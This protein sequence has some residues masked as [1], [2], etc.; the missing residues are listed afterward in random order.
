[1][2]GPVDA[3]DGLVG[4]GRVATIEVR[5][6]R[7]ARIGAMD[8]LRVLP[9]K[10][11]RTVGAWCFVDL[12]SP[13]D[14]D[15]PPP[16]EVGPH[17]HIGLSTVTWLFSGSALHSDSLGTEQL[18]RPGQLNL[19]SAG[20]GIAHAELGVD[21]GPAH[22]TEGVMGA[23]MW[24]AQ[25]DATRHGPSGFVHIADVPRVESGEAVVTVLVGEHGGETSPAATDHP[26]VGLDVHLNR[27]TRIE[28]RP[29]FEYGVVPIDRPIS[30]DGVIGE[31]GSL[32]LVPIGHESLALDARSDRARMMIV[33]GAPLDS[34]IQMWWN[35]VARS[36][37]EITAAWRDWRDHNDDRF[38]PVPS[39][40][41]RI[42]APVPPWVEV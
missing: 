10:G 2:S 33:G 30:V 40:L 35:F 37:D 1:M 34:R 3:S 38:G 27:S 12:M 5:E 7:T 28:I 39:E 31:P 13:E 6:G 22:D 42:E 9:T 24:L 20:Q 36:R 4:G 41:A 18:I 8:V 32:V 26:T 17:P 11:R 14:I 15:N 16:L 23:Q 25:T 21:A 29:D 19:M